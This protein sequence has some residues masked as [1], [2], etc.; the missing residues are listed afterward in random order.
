MFLE[1]IDQKSAEQAI[2]NVVLA[3]YHDFVDSLELDPDN[4]LRLHELVSDLTEAA[5]ALLTV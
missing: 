1:E 4:E 5:A 2:Y 3:E